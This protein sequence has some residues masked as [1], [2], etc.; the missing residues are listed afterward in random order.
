[1]KSR[2]FMKQS[3]KT[4]NSPTEQKS[5]QVI[6]RKFKSSVTS[7][8]PN[9]VTVKETTTIEK[10]YKK[11]NNVEESKTKIENTSSSSKQGTNLGISS[12]NKISISTKED[13]GQNKFSKLKQHGKYLSNRKKEQISEEKKYTKKEIDMIIKIQKWWKRI[14]AILNGYKIR[15]KLKKEKTNINVVKNREVVR[16]KYT[17]N[18]SYGHKVETTLGKNTSTSTNKVNTASNYKISS[19]INP[20]N[21]TNT[22]SNTSS[23]TNINSYTKYSNTNSNTNTH[24]INNINKNNI[25][26]NNNINNLQKNQNTKSYNNISSIKSINTNSQKNLNIN[27]NLTSSSSQKYVQS[28]STKSNAYTNKYLSTSPNVQTN[29]YLIET[30][31]VE[32][33]KKPK[34]YSASKTM[35]KNTVTSMTEINRYE[36][37]DIM[38]KIWNEESYCSTVES[39]CCLSDGNKSLNASENN[40]IIEDYEEEIKKL[41]MLLMEKDEE[42]N[43]LITDLNETKNQ[44][45]VK[46]TS[47]YNEYNTNKNYQQEGIKML[48]QKKTNWNEIN[49]PSPVS[50]IFIQSFRTKFN[51]GMEYNLE[52]ISEKIKKEESAQETISDSEAVLEIQEMNALSIISNKIRAK[53]ICQ[54]LQ[55]LMIL[56]KKNEEEEPLIFQKIEEI[57]ITSIL[58]KGRNQI[59]ELDG[60]EIISMKRIPKNMVQ[61]VD[62]I[63]IKSLIKAEVIIQELDGLEILKL[64]K[65]PHIPQCVDELEIQREYDMLLVKPTWTGLQIQGSGL[66]LLAMQRETALENQEIDEFEIIAKKKDENKMQSLDKISII[67][68]KIKKII[69]IKKGERFGFKGIAKKPEIKYIERY[70]K[71]NKGKIPNEIEAIEQIELLGVK[72]IVEV[73]VEKKEIK[74]EKKVIP[75]RIIKNDRFIIKGKIKEEIIQIKRKGLVEKIN[76][77]VVSKKEEKKEIKEEP[78]ISEIENI[79]SF[80]INK[81]YETVKPIVLEKID[82]TKVTRPIKSTKLLIK[83]LPH[84]EKEKE[85]LVVE[86]FAFNLEQINKG[87]KGLLI[88]NIGGVEI[89]GV[90]GMILKEGPAQTIIIKKE[91]VLSPSKT[92]RFNLK[93]KI[94]K[95]ELKQISENRLQIKGQ[96]KVKIDPKENIKIV[97][98]IIEKK[99]NWNEFN[100]IEHNDLSFIHLKKKIILLPQG[101]IPIE[102]IGEELPMH[103]KIVQL[104]PKI[105][106]KT[107][108]TASIQLK[109]MEI[110]QTKKIEQIIIEKPKVK[111]IEQVISTIELLGKEMPEQHKIVQLK[112]KMKIKLVKQASSSIKL[113]GLEIPKNKK[114]IIQTEKIIKVTKTWE[115]LLQAQRNAKFSLLGKPKQIKKSKLLVANGDKFCFQKESDDEIIFNDDYN[116]RKQKQKS[117]KKEKEKEKEKIQIIKEKEVVPRFQREIRAQIAR[118]RESESETS[119]ISEIDVLAGIKNKKIIEGD[120]IRLKMANGYETK[121]I[122]GEVIFTQKNGLGIDLGGSQYQKQFK[123]NINYTK[124]LQSS[125]S[126]NKMTGIEIN[127]NPNLR[128]QVHLEKTFATSGNIKEGNFRVNENEINLNNGQ[129]GSRRQIIIT[130]MT[131]NNEINGLPNI[132]L[133][134]KLTGQRSAS[135]LLIKKR[136]SNKSNKS[137]ESPV[138]ANI[139]NDINQQVKIGKVIYNSKMKVEKGQFTPNSSGNISGR[140][141]IVSSKQEY[142]KKIAMTGDRNNEN[143]KN[144]EIKIKKSK[145]KKIEQLRD[146]D[147]QNNY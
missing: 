107:Q 55:S 20:A 99:I 123:R 100:I 106:F 126:S 59:Q 89:E 75:N 21:K 67:K 113:I 70:I 16:E 138:S 143:K 49:L 46:Y 53:N 39:L 22:N 28:I 109:G 91:Q 32:I 97:E 19:N 130:S 115:N 4:D 60:L 36:V 88:V 41:K 78:K 8:G 131:E 86:S 71:E 103:Q 14:L 120:K 35:S 68:N 114:E 38:L 85:E 112:P 11:V 50:E 80:E 118:V 141:I 30:K 111:L 121:V 132:Q 43:H 26:I 134:S 47:T 12:Q 73:K 27:T 116:T 42:L 56:S 104:K 45:S 81:E 74:V 93:Q 87:F 69:S 90:K 136:E 1:M 83:A 95:I 3:I 24:S 29:K 129:S 33:F 15:E 61:N 62:K 125:L 9:Q 48:S 124:K 40:L 84:I 2:R 110:P 51:S 145:N 25:N 18:S 96:Y 63:N 57:N 58:K 5:S 105:K 127:F 122:D 37:K 17:S 82:W 34:N 108:A 137:N 44:L 79:E 13:Q 94:K 142:E 10:S 119:S 101:P 140:N 76:K 6:S 98:K 64:D 135:N 117:E 102:L 128:S 23:Y 54:H 52:K 77:Q 146:Y 7:Q 65:T 66:N 92:E 144:V 31:K 133:T 139:N 147:A 72:K